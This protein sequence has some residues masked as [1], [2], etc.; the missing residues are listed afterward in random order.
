M[1]RTERLRR[2]AGYLRARLPELQLGKVPDPRS[3]QGRRW[4]LQALLKSVLLG[5][6]AGIKGLGEL[7]SLDTWLTGDIRCLLGLPES[8]ADT[9]VRDVLCRLDWRSLRKVLHPRRSQRAATKGPRTTRTAV[10]HGL[11]RR[12]SDGVTKRR[13]PLRAVAYT[14]QWQTLRPDARTTT[15]TLV[16]AKGRPCV[17]VT[18]IPAHTNEMGH[19]TYAFGELVRLYGDLIK[20]F[21][22]DAG[23]GSEENGKAVVRA[24]KHYLFRLADERWHLY[25][26]AMELLCGTE[27]VAESSEVRSQHQYVRRRLRTFGVNSG[28]LPAL[29]RNTEI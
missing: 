18:P 20:L 10:S 23:A 11:A 27:V 7:E 5:L 12:Q 21:S 3:R 26:L 4:Q 28:K 8:I 15:A 17:D 14:R 9:T 6:M 22:Y 1:K 25:Q 19:F 2:M 24:G 16:T 13:R 29:A